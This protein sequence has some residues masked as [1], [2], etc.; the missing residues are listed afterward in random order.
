[1][2]HVLILVLTAGLS[3]C[4]AGSSRVADDGV[5]PVVLVTRD[6][7]VVRLN[8]TV[9]QSLSVSEANLYY[10]GSDIVWRGDPPGNRYEQVEALFEQG[11]GRGFRALDGDRDVVV[12]IVVER[13]HSVTEKARY[14]VGGVHSIR[15]LATVRDARSGEIVEGPQFVKADLVALGGDNAIEADRQGNTQKVRVTNHLSEVALELYSPPT[16]AG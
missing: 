16:P 9:P 3:A 13:F 4:A 1:M 10:P 8:V 15:F 14:T 6:Y 5:D 11:M 2:K 7:N 12:D